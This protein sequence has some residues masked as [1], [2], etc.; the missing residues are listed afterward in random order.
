[1]PNMHDRELLYLPSSSLL[2][3]LLSHYSTLRQRNPS[4][5]AAFA[6][7]YSVVKTAINP[8]MIALF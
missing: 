2:L 3:A 5:A 8:G 7:M 6:G 4:S 1:M